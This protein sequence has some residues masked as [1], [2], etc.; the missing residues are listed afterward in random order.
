MLTRPPLS[1]PFPFP[2]YDHAIA[3]R[4]VLFST[5]PSGFM[6]AIP[7]S[8]AST[9]RP[10]PQSTLHTATAPRA[11]ILTQNLP[12]SPSAKANHNDTPP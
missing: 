12:E 3:R 5:V 6:G 8:H 9:T 4:A 7:P 11:F 1:T 2:T 10:A